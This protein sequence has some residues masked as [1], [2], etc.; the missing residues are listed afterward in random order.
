[1]AAAI[2]LWDDFDGPALRRLAKGTK[3]AA[4]ARRL[5][6]LAEIRDGGSR[7]DAARVGGVGLQTIRDWVLRFNARGPAGLI[8]GKAPG[9][10]SKLDDSQR[11]ALAAIV[12]RG[13]IPAIHEVVRWRLADLAHWIWEEFGISLS[14]TTVGR[15]LRALGYRKISARPR[16]HA[17]NELAIEDFKKGFSA[18]L[19][20]IREG[21]PAGTEIELWWQDEA[22]AG[23]K[24]SI[25][26][27]WAKRGTRPRAPHDQR[28]KWA[29]IFGAIRPKKGKGAALVMPWCDTPAPL[30]RL[31]CNRLPGNEW[32]PTWPRSARPSIPAPMPC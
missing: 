10:A 12:E 7:A 20:A 6:A 28:T 3:D 18:E 16:H 25:T 26:R 29:Y 23:Q 21:L 17:Q 13:P 8:D 15:E 27:R 2:A 5:L 32:P 30:G 24:N 14:E 22:R 19:E 11:Q 1:M 31:L 4:Q 9:D